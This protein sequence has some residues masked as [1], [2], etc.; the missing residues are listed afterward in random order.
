MKFLV[1]HG[2]ELNGAFGVM[3]S[4]QHKG[5][6]AAIKDGVPWAG[7]L[8]C[9]DGPDYV[10]RID[11]RRAIEWLKEMEPYREQCMFIAGADVVGKA[12]DTLDA[13]EEFGRYFAGW[14]LAYVVQNGAE[15]LPFPAGISAIFLGGDTEYKESMTAVSVI[16]RAQAAGLHIHIGRVNWRRRYDLFRVL[17]GSDQFTCDGTRQRYDGVEKALDAWLN[18][19]SQPPLITI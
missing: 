1:S 19:E 9:L 3:T 2:G 15:H 17:E 18:Y 8:G 14:P 4:P 10:K 11:F 16:K 7:D 13:F 5:V 6:P 12:Q